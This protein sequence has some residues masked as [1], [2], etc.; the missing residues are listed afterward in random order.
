M[1]EPTTNPTVVCC[2]WRVVKS[3]IIEIVRFRVEVPFGNGSVVGDLCQKQAQR[4]KGT[5][6]QGHKGTRA[7]GHKERER[8][9]KM[10]TGGSREKEQEV[11]G[12]REGERETK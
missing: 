11:R 8:K 1:R 6:A 9:G 3:P 2:Q 10:G 7:Q 4:H 12:R 5:R